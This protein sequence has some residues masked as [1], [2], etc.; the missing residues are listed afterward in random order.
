M[1][2]QFVT[3]GITT[4]SLSAVS[5]F[6][7][8]LAVL[9]P[10]SNSTAL[11]MESSSFSMAPVSE[12]YF[13]IYPLRQG[14][15]TSAGIDTTFSIPIR[16][17]GA[18]ISDIYEVEVSTTWSIE[19]YG[20]D[21]FTPLSDTNNNGTKDTGIIY[22]GQTFELITVIDTPSWADAG[23]DSRTDIN[24]SSTISPTISETAILQVAIPAPFV[25]GFRD[26]A[27][28]A[29]SLILAEPN[30]QWTKKTTSDDYDAIGAAVVETPAGYAY[31]WS[32]WR[33]NNGQWMSEIEYLLTDKSGQP[34]TPI[35]QLTDHSTATLAT[36]D[37]RP[38]IAATPE[39]YLGISWQRQIFDRS[40]A[41]N[42]NIYF[43]TTDPSGQLLINPTNI[44][45]ISGWVTT[46]TLDIP[47]VDFSRV[48]GTH[49]ERYFFAWQSS[50]E[51]AGGGVRDIH[52]AVRDR[53][54]DTFTGTTNYT[55]DVPD[56]IGYASPIVT[57]LT[58]NRVLL[59]WVR[60]SPED[61]DIYY[62]IINSDGSV[63]RP[64]NNLSR[65]E[66]VVDWFTSSATELSDGRIL[67]AWNAWGCSES[68][69]SGRT[70]MA[71][72]G[73]NYNPN[74]NPVCLEDDAG[75]AIGGD[76]GVSLAADSDTNAIITWTD[77]NQNERR[78]LY[79]ALVDSHLRVQTEP[80]IYHRSEVPPFSM[81]WE[82]FANTSRLYIDGSAKFSTDGYLPQEGEDAEVTIF[83]GNAGTVAAS[84]GILTAT[85]H[86][87]LSYVGVSGSAPGEPIVDG[88]HLRWLLQDIN[89]LDIQ[90]FQLYLELS[91]SGEQWVSYPVTITLELAEPEID[92]ANNS[93]Q[94]KVTFGVRSI[95]LPTIAK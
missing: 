39:G 27:D 48:A 18:V 53:S 87:G 70:K 74:G 28:D 66:K 8:L 12:D 14:Q 38:T 4:A 1:R 7:L 69:F 29:M 59:T 16:N 52:Y 62:A 23:D 33:F 73:A 82:G 76:Y 9:L 68:N 84:S 35:I 55:N 94:T 86:P 75:I 43:A 61:D 60:R 42:S 32:K 50:H 58:N 45:M 51:E 71:V 95:Y 67:V 79:Y 90:P 46:S 19:L 37:L 49:D 34:T 21:G 6:W 11:E 77:A 78:H 57:D 31:V 36:Q 26:H 47:V 5:L 56:D 22:H 54:E 72:L 17:N 3:I 20:P 85:L 80:M 83:Y 88:N 30:F 15:F 44:T 24:I 2:R 81:S 89:L 63:F 93:D 41:V 10:Q 13:T 65:S 25:Q 91:G 92:L 64:T 40:G